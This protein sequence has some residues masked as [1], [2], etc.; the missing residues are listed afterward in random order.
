MFGMPV[1]ALRG[2]GGRASR[3]P[4]RRRRARILITTGVTAL[5]GAV[6]LQ[7]FAPAA[8]ADGAVTPPGTHAR[9]PAPSTLRLPS[10][11]PSAQQS[12]AAL[13]AHKEAQAKADLARVNSEIARDTPKQAKYTGFMISPAVA[14]FLSTGLGLTDGGSRLLVGL[15][16]RSGGDTT[17]TA[18]VR[19]P[20]LAGLLPSGVTAPALSAAVITVDERTGALTVRSAGKSGSLSVAVASAGTAT[21]AGGRGLTSL[22]RLDAPV[23]GVPVGLSGTLAD[24]GGKAR[25]T[26]AGALPQTVPRGPVEL[27]A[28]DTVSVTAAGVTLTGAVLLGQSGHQ[29]RAS[30]SGTVRDSADWTLSATGTTA[31]GALLPGLGVG[32]GLHGTVADSHG[33]VTFDVHATQAGIWRP[34]G[35]VAVTGAGVEFANTLPRTG[36]VEA[37]GITRRTPWVDVAGGLAM[38]AGSGVAMTAAGTVAVNLASGKGLLTGTQRG[39]L[40]VTGAGGPAALGAAGFSGGLTLGRTGLTGTVR[41]TGLVTIRPARGRPVYALTSFTVAGTS[42]VRFSVPRAASAS[43]RARLSATG[44]ATTMKPADGGAPSTSYTLS[45]SVYSFLSSTLGIPLGGSPTVTG[46]LS[47]DTLTVATG[48]LGTLRVSLP[49]GIAAPTF[50]PLTITVDE[51]TDTLS[52]DASATGSTAATLDVTI[53]SASTSTLSGTDLTATLTFPSVPFINGSTVSLAGSLGYSGAALTASL[54]GTLNS[55]ITI[56]DGATIDAGTTVTLDGDGP[57]LTVSGYVSVPVTPPGG[58]TSTLSA[59]VSG[60]IS[61][62]SAWSLTVS[63][64]SSSSWQ[65][66]TGLTVQPSFSGTVSDSGGSVSFTITAGSAGSSTPLVTWSPGAQA[67]FSLDD[68]TVSSVAPT[69]A[70]DCPDG[71]TAGQVWLG[72]SGGFE[73]DPAGTGQTLTAGFCADL[74]NGHFTVVTA[75]TG[76]LLSGVGTGF[77]LSAV[78]LTATDNGTFSVTASAALNI[79]GSALPPATL[80]VSFG[81]GTIIGA[82][83]VQDVGSYFPGFTGDGNGAIYVSSSQLASFNPADYGLP[84]P[85]FPGLVSLKAGLTVTYQAPLP[86]YIRNN[87]DDVLPNGTIPDTSAE[88]IAYLGTS[89]F[90]L[91]LALNLH[92]GSSSDMQPVVDVDNTIVYLDDIDFG[93]T[94]GLTTTV[95][96]KGSATLMLPGMLAG[97]SESSVQVNVGASFDLTDTSLDLTLGLATWNPAFG[98]S[99][100]SVENLTLKVGITA[101]ALPVISLSADSITLPSSV[102]TA[103]GLYYGASVSFDGALDP[104]N[105]FL[106]IQVTPPAGSPAGTPALLPLTA[107][108]AGL[109]S[110]NNTQFLQVYSVAVSEADLYL[111]PDGGV[112]A[113]GA[114]LNPGVSVT[115]SATIDNVPVNALASVGISPPGLLINMTAGQFQ[116]GS[117]SLG[118]TTLLVEANEDAPL[119]IEFM[120]SASFDGLSVAAAVNLNYGNSADG[121]SVTLTLNGGLPSFLSAGVRVTGTVAGDWTSADASLTGYGAFSFAGQSFGTVQFSLDLRGAFSWFDNSDAITQI[122]QWFQN[123]GASV[124]DIISVLQA[125]GQSAWETLQELGE[126]GISNSQVISDLVTVFTD[127]F[128][129]T[130]LYIWNYPGFGALPYV[131][132]VQGQSQSP[133]AAVETEP[134]EYHFSQQWALMESPDD[135]GWY[136]IVNRSSAQCL[137]VLNNGPLVQYPCSNWP[138]QLWYFGNPTAGPEYVL[139]NGGSGEVMDVEGANVNPYTP[140]DEWSYNNGDNQWFWLTAG[141]NIS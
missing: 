25:L 100:L 42:G 55:G 49:D 118:S 63:G 73:Y 82:V 43:L 59:S 21:L 51:S 46:T 136:E 116:L 24:G 7:A 114:S 26:L 38:T 41:G 72:G 131:V 88:T 135:P 71:I 69:P 40:P 76:T 57:S 28:G 108:F 102:S 10:G 95:S 23:L 137:S 140:L 58:T 75:A 122:I 18:T 80:A 124:Q 92:D 107:A 89:G 130:Y 33:D 112:A 70:D 45:S 83:Q 139:T 138:S 9:Q 132:G 13:E 86:D 81:S 31:G 134:L 29:L 20:K 79:T 62:L 1:S 133:D 85:A 90:S 12:F 4:G 96:L 87:L 8:M 74:S 22:I 14:A 6:A 60:S 117:L 104:S 115:F 128:S 27:L 39:S 19:T 32:S 98:V 53:A 111:A 5:A 65:P 141:T 99:G 64:T 47:G 3:P 105:P 34:V 121:A 125:L 110:L 113:S 126:A 120:G 97:T 129:S 56:A 35:G 68:L 123:S 78:A 93:F 30:V 77:S 15:R 37:P 52:F 109:S 48:G 103:I 44:P 84:G 17:L 11:F 91:D 54:T 101:E 16:G 36:A 66:V 94:L 106:H 67:S 119:R 127:P 50:G 61:S 2:P